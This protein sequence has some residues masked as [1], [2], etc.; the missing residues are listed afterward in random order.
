MSVSNEALAY[1]RVLVWPT[2]LG[3]VLLSFRSTI[4]GLLR[5]RLTQIDA[6]GFSAHFEQVVESAEAVAGERP[7]PKDDGVRV[8]KVTTG[9][10]A[11]PVIVTLGKT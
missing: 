10:R 6:A 9:P 7:A 4:R 1:L 2:V 11:E 8:D 3:V 5:V